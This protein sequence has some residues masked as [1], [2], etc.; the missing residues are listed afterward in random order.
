MTA[1]HLF[2]ERICQIHRKDKRR[3]NP[4]VLHGSENDDTDIDGSVVS[5]EPFSLFDLQSVTAELA[6]ESV[7]AYYDATVGTFVDNVL[8]LCIWTPIIMQLQDVF[9]SEVVWNRMDLNTIRRLAGE[10][11][12]KQARRADLQR[13]LQALENGKKEC[14]PYSI[15]VGLGQCIE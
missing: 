6:L 11:E 3:A 7:E 1:N 15:A 12:E 8:T 5:D 4:G 10:S 13:K 9:S 2:L 14:E